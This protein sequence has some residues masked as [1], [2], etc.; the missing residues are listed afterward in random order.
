MVAF[1]IH[2]NDSTFVSDRFCPLQN[3]L[4]PKI[5]FILLSDRAAD[6]KTSLNKVHSMKKGGDA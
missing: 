2:H 4:D 1:K 3:M 6:L 5:D